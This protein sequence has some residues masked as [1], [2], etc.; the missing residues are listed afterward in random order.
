MWRAIGVKIVFNVFLPNL[1]NEFS[2]TSMYF[3]MYSYHKGS[4]YL[5]N[6]CDTYNK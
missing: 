4:S 6:N 3:I 2:I 5:Y 1:F